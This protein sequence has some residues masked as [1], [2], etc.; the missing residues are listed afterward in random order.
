VGREAFAPQPA[1]STGPTVSAAIIPASTFAIGNSLS[2]G[3][4]GR[5]Y[6]HSMSANGIDDLWSCSSCALSYA[7]WVFTSAALKANV[8]F[9]VLYCGPT[10]NSSTCSTSYSYTFSSQSL[11]TIGDG[12][13][14]IPKISY[15]T[16]G[17]YFAEVW[18]NNHLASYIPVTITG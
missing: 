3:P 16:S 2:V 10:G 13:S 17:V 14:I 4:D 5:G 8:E 9:R 7:F 18:V 15:K 1:G 12:Y 11:D 6:G